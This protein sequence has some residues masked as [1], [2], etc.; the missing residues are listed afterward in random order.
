MLDFTKLR[1]WQQ[2]TIGDIGRIGLR[3]NG[4]DIEIWIKNGEAV[5][6]YSCLFTALKRFIDSQECEEIAL[7]AIK[8]LANVGRRPSPC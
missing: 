4:G 8:H 7:A 1:D 6:Y 2:S 3:K 5:T